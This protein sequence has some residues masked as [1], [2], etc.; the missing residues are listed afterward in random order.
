MGEGRGSVRTAGGQRSPAMSPLVDAR[1]VLFCFIYI[2]FH[3]NVSAAYDA[4]CT[5]HYRLDDAPRV[6]SHCDGY[7]TCRVCSSG[8]GVDHCPS[9]SL[10][11]RAD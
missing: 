3:S 9:V 8:G 7:S 2:T 6:H 4:A 5:R 10:G 11:L 1:K